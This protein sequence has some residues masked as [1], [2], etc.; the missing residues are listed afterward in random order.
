MQREGHEKRYY[1][2][3]IAT[4]TLILTIPLAYLTSKCWRPLLE[5]ALRFV[6]RRTRVPARV[7]VPQPWD[8]RTGV[9]AMIDEDCVMEAKSLMS[10]GK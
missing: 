7:P 9:L 3:I 4:V 10:R 8:V 1:G 2:W 5:I 6:W